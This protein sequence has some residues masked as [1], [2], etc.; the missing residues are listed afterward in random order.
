[1]TGEQSRKPQRR[2]TVVWEFRVK[3]GQQRAFE[4]AYGPEGDWVKL[5][6]GSADYLGTRLI[7]DRDTALRYVTLDRWTSRQAYSRFKKQNREAYKSID[8]RCE[9][10]TTQEEFIGE[11]EE[12]EDV[13]IPSDAKISF[14]KLRAGSLATE[15]EQNPSRTHKRLGEQECPTHADSHVRRATPDDIPAIISLERNNASAAHWPDATYTRIFSEETPERIKL[16]LQDHRSHLN[17]FVIARLINE[18]CELENIVV[19][20]SRQNGGLGTQLMR[21]LIH[22]S[23]AQNAARIFLEVRES[24]SA[25]RGLYEKCGFALTGRRLAYYT[26]PAEDAILYTLKL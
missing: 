3:R 18:D 9:A 20:R 4:K 1:M 23:K 11:F 13:E 8:A 19:A 2:F 17:G 26:N 15:R 25:A 16:V 10:L 6:R 5:F 12:F 7:R 14:D 21:E 24:N 22:A